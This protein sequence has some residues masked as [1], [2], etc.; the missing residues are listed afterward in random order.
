MSADPAFAALRRARLA[1]IE[2][3]RNG[4]HIHYETDGELPPEIIEGL[5]QH[6]PAILRILAAERCEASQ[7]AGTLDHPLLECSYAGHEL[8]L[9][10]ACIASFIESDTAAS[11]RFAPQYVCDFCGRPPK[12]EYDFLKRA[13]HRGGPPG[14]VPV[15]RRCLKA[16]FA[17]LDLEPLP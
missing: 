3:T 4:P 7:G 14:G 9:H 6:K 2:V 13:S 8:L 16:W 5:R 12:D 11:E 1:G 10:H 15:H 17:R